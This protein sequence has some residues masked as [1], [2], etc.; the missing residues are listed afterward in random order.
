[1][2]RKTA[3]LFQLTL[4]SLVLCHTLALTQPAF[5]QSQRAMPTVESDIPK[6]LTQADTLKIDGA[7][8]MA[9]I[10]QLLETQY[11]AAFPN[12]E[13]DWRAN[14]TDMALQKLLQGEIDL[15]AIARPLT[16]GEKAQGLREVP[17]SLD[18]IA[19]IVGRNNP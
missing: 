7:P 12:T 8:T 16:P 4:L 18:N 6:A 9:V 10:N 19:I 15:A 3:P 5:A 13:I 11:E 1:M 17:V 14:G 2:M